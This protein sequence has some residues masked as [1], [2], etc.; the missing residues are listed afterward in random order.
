MLHIVDFLNLNYFDVIQ[1]VIRWGPCK[2][3][4]FGIEINVLY[5]QQ[6]FMSVELV[7]FRVYRSRV[8]DI[9]LPL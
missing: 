7:S 9:W 2:L 3:M 1:E 5:P 8:L 6:Q 4:L